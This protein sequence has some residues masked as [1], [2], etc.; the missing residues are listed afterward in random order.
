M[1]VRD[2]E[3]VASAIGAAWSRLDGIDLLV[4]NAGIGMRTVNPRL[5]IPKS[6]RRLQPC[7]SSQLSGCR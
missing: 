3:S 4:N 1:D 6:V 2:E 7:E 5:S